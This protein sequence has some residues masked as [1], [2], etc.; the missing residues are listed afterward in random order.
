MKKLLFAILILNVLHANAQ[1]S[2]QLYTH[3]NGIDV[4]TK[5]LEGSD[6]KAVKTVCVLE[7][8]LSKIAYVLMDVDRTTDWVYGTKSC[9]L[10][11]SFTPNDL[12][13][14][15]EIALPW[16]A[17][18]RDFIIRITLTQDPITKAITIRA[19][20]KPTY[21]PEKKNLVR[22]QQ[23]SGFW[24]ISPLGNGR[25]RVEYTLQVDP[26]GY[27]PAWLVNL[28]AANGPYDSARNLGIQLNKPVYKNA[29]LTSII[30]E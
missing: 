16:P 10:L 18:N 13:Y 3:K 9:K 5:N 1:S 2:W 27:L 29:S 14:Y 24:Q 25:V 19:I 26:G 7:T 28:F 8:S 4:F 20:N 21:I 30:N 6:F 15:A 22:I 23:S 17:S 12:I 11:H